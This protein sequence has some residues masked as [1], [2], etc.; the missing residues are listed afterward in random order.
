MRPV[1]HRGAKRVFNAGNGPY[2][3]FRKPSLN[4]YHVD[5]RTL[6]TVTA[7]LMILWT[8]FVGAALWLTH[9]NR[10]RL[11]VRLA[12]QQARL[13][14]QAERALHVGGQPFGQENL[15]GR[16]HVYWKGLPGTRGASAPDEWESR[17][18]TGIEPNQEKSELAV[19]FGEKQLRWLAPVYDESACLSC[20]EPA[21]RADGLR[22]G[23]SILVPMES[24]MA[25][26]APA[27]TRQVQ[28]H[29]GAWLL[30]C[31][32]LGLAA[33]A[34]LRAVRERDRITANLQ[35]ALQA[36][37]TIL[38]QVPFGMVIVD[39]N[40]NVRHVNRYAEE[41][42]GKPRAE[43]VDGVC[44][45][46]FCPSAK[47]A[48]PILDLRQTVDNSE[49]RILNA[50]GDVVPVQKSVIPVTWNGEDVLLEAFIDISE[51]K[52][53]IAEQEAALQEEQRLNRLTVGREL[54]MV[55]LKEEVNRLLNEAGA[56]PKYRIAN[57][58]LVERSEKSVGADSANDTES[59]KVRS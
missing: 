5:V 4:L 27:W 15:H 20:H 34:I 25:F 19:R 3:R 13:H 55:Q 52:A 40:K 14:Y 1:R 41:L 46:S 26:S 39:R 28:A 10:E 37:E 12:T 2:V 57:P 18:L 42:I 38:E 29:L 8:G 43:I 45:N 58:S 21:Q 22:G 30:G 56:D 53:L 59:S 11:S 7:G 24:I 36:N 48:C 50:D 17:S 49:R 32:L 35:S 44:T 54:R 47:D 33:H 23:A 6:L 51:Q 16:V 9:V 31:G